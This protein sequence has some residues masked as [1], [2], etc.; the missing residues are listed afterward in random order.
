[1]IFSFSKVRSSSVYNALVNFLRFTLGTLLE[2]LDV[3]V[4]LLMRV[5]GMVVACDPWKE[6]ADGTA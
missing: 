2:A 6:A 4:W 5:G 1:M 3:N